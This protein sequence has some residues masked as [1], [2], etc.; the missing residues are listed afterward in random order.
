MLGIILAALTAYLLFAYPK[1]ILAR[2]N[3]ASLKK[4]VENL[5][6]LG[7]ET[8]GRNYDSYVKDGKFDW[9]K[10]KK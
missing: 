7:F 3:M 5:I 6:Y 9:K 4:Q 8:G 1:V 2:E 10:S